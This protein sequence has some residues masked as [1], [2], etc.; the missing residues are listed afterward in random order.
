MIYTLINQI[1]NW[2]YWSVEIKQALA[3]AQNNTDVGEQLV[4]ENKKLKV[5]TIHLKPNY[6]L[7]F[8]KHHKKYMWT[9]L[10]QGKSISYYN[11]G[12]VKETI[13]ELGDTRNFEDLSEENYFIH[14]LINTGDTTLIF[15]TIEFK[16]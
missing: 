4:Y 9:A 15:S 8:H 14:N 5:W 10:S 7:P 1:G 2:D 16:T 12:S 11:D 3:E 13:Y 6:S